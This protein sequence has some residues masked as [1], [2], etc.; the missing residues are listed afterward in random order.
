VQIRRRGV[1]KCV[2]RLLGMLRAARIALADPRRPGA[3]D[4]LAAE[5]DAALTE[6]GP[7]HWPSEA[8]T[9]VARK[10]KLVDALHASAAETRKG[11]RWADVQVKGEAAPRRANGVRVVRPMRIEAVA[12]DHY[13]FQRNA[14]DGNYRHEVVVLHRESFDVAPWPASGWNADAFEEMFEYRFRSGDSE[15]EDE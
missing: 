3:L 13:V 9:Q 4:A 6:P 7:P 15:D 14:G 5:R 8:N 1:L 2:P 12:G 10:R 11:A